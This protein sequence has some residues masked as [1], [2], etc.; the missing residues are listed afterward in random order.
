MMMQM[1]VRY[2]VVRIMQRHC[3]FM[4]EHSRDLLPDFFYDE[5][6]KNAMRLQERLWLLSVMCNDVNSTTTTTT[7]MCWPTELL[8][9]ISCLVVEMT[10]ITLLDAQEIPPFD[11][12]VSYLWYDQVP[13]WYSDGIDIDCDDAR[14][15]VDNNNNNN[16]SYKAVLASHDYIDLKRKRST[17]AT[18]ALLMDVDIDITELVVEPDDP[19]PA[20]Q[21]KQKIRM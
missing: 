16:P 8:Q 10:W 12:T 17:E 6:V 3:V 13:A 5:A 15:G 20:P 11:P 4:L 14:N 7:T 19:N 9:T 21:K 1:G 18:T 2:S